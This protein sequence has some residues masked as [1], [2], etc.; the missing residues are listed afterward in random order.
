MQR[1]R[2]PL[3]LLGLVLTL[4]GGSA[5]AEVV[6]STAVAKVTTDPL[7]AAGVSA[8]PTRGTQPMLAEVTSV[9]AGEVLRYTITFSNQGTLDVA[10]GSIVITNPLPEGCEY[11]EGS[12]GGANTV[13]SYSIDGENFGPAADL[14]V[15]AGGTVRRAT[16]ADYRSIRWTFRPGLA[17]GESG[18]VS[19]DVRIR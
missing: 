5:V 8:E 15:P 13:V 1:V 14:T 10:P 2:Y 11:L 4:I 17:A 18:Q 6:L 12:A 16:P 9:V 3:G 7:S 19:F